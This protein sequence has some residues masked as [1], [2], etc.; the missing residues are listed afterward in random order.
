MFGRRARMTASVRVTS[1]GIV[2]IAVLVSSIL[3]STAALV[4]TARKDV[5]RPREG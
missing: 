3:L 2:S 1:P 5:R 4:H